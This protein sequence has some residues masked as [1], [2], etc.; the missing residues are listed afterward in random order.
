MKIFAH[1][2]ENSLKKWWGCEREKEKLSVE[3]MKTENFLS[4]ARREKRKTEN[5]STTD[6]LSENDCGLN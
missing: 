2:Y 1:K 4:R 6:V 5:L 3:G